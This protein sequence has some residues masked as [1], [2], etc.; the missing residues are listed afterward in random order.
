MSCNGIC[1]R[2]KAKRMSNTT[3]RYEHNRQKRCSICEIFIV[4]DK[5]TCPCCNYRLRTRSFRGS[6]VKQRYKELAIKRY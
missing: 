2:Y 1:V 3:L 4:W 5:T 6:G